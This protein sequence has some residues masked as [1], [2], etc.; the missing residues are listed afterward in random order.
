M[1]LNIVGETHYFSRSNRASIDRVK[2]V[3]IPIPPRK[4][5]D[6]IAQKCAS[7]DSEYNSSRMT[8]EE[9]RYRIKK[10][11]L[12]FQIFVECK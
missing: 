11:F 5:Q 7:I 4:I 3:E 2:G 9:Y 12:G 6:E 10:I 1:A 8:M